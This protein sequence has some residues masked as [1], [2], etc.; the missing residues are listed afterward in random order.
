MMERIR[1]VIK[2]DHKKGVQLPQGVAAIPTPKK[3]K[4]IDRYPELS[5]FVVDNDES[6]AEHN[7]AIEA[8][9]R[10]SKPKDTNIVPLM[11]STFA[12]RRPYILEDAVSVKD[13]LERYPALSRPVIVSYSRYLIS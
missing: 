12:S 11:K 3:I 7:T 5:P 6:I 9:L 8:E 10:R 13:I 4:K 2:I 1:N